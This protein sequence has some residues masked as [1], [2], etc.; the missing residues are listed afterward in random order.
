MNAP[1]RT[2][3]AALCLLAA[4]AQ[5][6]VWGEDG[7]R[8]V[9]W[10]AY[11]HL[12]DAARTEL[13]RLMATESTDL[14]EAAY[15]PD[16]VARRLTE[17]R[18]ANQL[19]YANVPDGSATYDPDRDRPAGGDVVSGI[20]MFG[21]QLADDS[22]PDAERLVAL[23]FL[24]HFV[25]DIHQPLHVGYKEDRGGN[26]T[27]IRFYNRRSK[28][29]AVWDTGILSRSTSDWEEFAA[30]L[31]D[32]LRPADIAAYTEWMSPLDWAQ[33]SYA[34]AVDEVYGRVEPNES[35]A[36]PYVDDMLPVVEEQL[37][38]AGVRLA[39]TLNEL[40]GD[41]GSVDVEQPVTLVYVTRSGSKYHASEC[42]Y[43]QSA[44]G[45]LTVSEAGDE[46]YEPCRLCDPPEADD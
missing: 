21:A 7:H 25:G 8:I 12:D 29:H 2:A 18:F 32:M 19:H 35:V 37:L 10:I 6:T 42:R 31:N 13:D 16:A 11:Q 15:W 5:A 46:G 28:L 45:A 26:D 30:Q 27:Y 40:V 39:A 9:G 3:A 43:A 34:I 22:L 24:A 4:A 14:P 38:A 1:I 44:V 33:E 36:A 20:E 17:Y 23:R 41:G